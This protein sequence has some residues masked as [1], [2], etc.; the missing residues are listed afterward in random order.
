M[1]TSMTRREF[2]GATTL[3]AAGHS[4][5]GFLARTAAAAA[6]TP[7]AAGR[8]LVV[9]QMTGGNDGLNTVVPFRDDRY[10]RARPTLAVPASS[11]LRLT[12]DIGLHPDM[13]G[14]KRLHDEGLLSVIEGVGYP[15]PDRSHFRSLDIWHTACLQPEACRT[16]WLGR[17]VDQLQRQAEAPAAI[18]LD[19]DALPL[20]LAAERGD[21]PSIRSLE[22]FRLRLPGGAGQAEAVQAAIAVTRPEQLEDLLFVQRA[23]L[24]SCANARRLEHVDASGTLA[25]SYP[26]HRLA[27]KLRQ[28]AQLIAAD[29]GPRIYYTSI[30]GF[31][32][33]AKQVLAHGP[34]LREIAESVSA[35]F[36]DLRARG[37]DDRVMLMTF[38]EFGRRL[39]ENGSQGTDHGAAAPM[40][41]AGPACRPG[42]IGAPPD[43]GLLEDGD[44][45]FQVDFRS[46]YAGLLADWLAIDPVPVLGER[47]APLAVAR[48]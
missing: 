32:T 47:F 3:L 24:S 8:V 17:A 37:L 18:H 42:V 13:T 14:F 5:P 20:A 34:L 28:I 6:A 29:F 7:A 11:V 10:H 2:L 15:N 1:M 40:F 25:G 43:L 16:G 33:H 36:V 26:D 31:D 39:A 48:T 27:G 46:V 45:R 22:A 30:N 12:D 9:L 38:S 23:A 21:V 41:L 44:V 19:D 4:L 35:F